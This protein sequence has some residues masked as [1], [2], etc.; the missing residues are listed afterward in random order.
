M[1]VT[2]EPFGE[3]KREG[4]P[5]PHS[6]RV[7]HSSWAFRSGSWEWGEGVTTS[8]LWPS[9]SSPAW[10]PWAKAKERVTD[11]T[12]GP[13]PGFKPCVPSVCLAP[14]GVGRT[15]APKPLELRSANSITC[16]KIQHGPSQCVCVRC[17]C[18]CMW[19]G[20]VTFSPLQ[21]SGLP[22]PPLQGLCDLPML[23]CLLAVPLRT[24][25]HICSQPG[26][27]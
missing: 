11:Q 9:S 14:Q 23:A 20:G 27:P 6:G 21:D 7:P 10:P 13:E 4:G 26:H 22:A 2:M 8:V 15:E 12:D 1:D 24:A 17:V 19:V 16:P 3:G 25:P 18:V 5:W